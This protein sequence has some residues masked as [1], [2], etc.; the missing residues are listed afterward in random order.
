MLSASSRAI[1]AHAVTRRIPNFLSYGGGIF[2]IFAAR[3]ALPFSWDP[4]AYMPVLSPV[5]RQQEHWLAQRAQ[6]DTINGPIV[7]AGAKFHN[8]LVDNKMLLSGVG[9]HW[10]S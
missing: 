8:T 9:C 10:L 6:P 3:I 4:D 1:L 7:E 5:F 2:A